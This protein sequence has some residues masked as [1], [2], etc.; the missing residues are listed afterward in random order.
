MTVDRVDPDTAAEIVGKLCPGGNAQRCWARYAL[1]SAEVARSISASSWAITLFANVVRLN[2]GQIAVLELWPGDAVFYCC[3]RVPVE[4][5]RTSSG[6]ESG[7]ATV[8]SRPKPSD[9]TSMQR[10]ASG[11]NTADQQAL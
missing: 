1:Q 6:R 4:P 5:S 2:V 3:A 7:T 10:T 11:A 9:G 8:Q